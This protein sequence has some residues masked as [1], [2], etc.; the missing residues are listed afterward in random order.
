MQKSGDLELLEDI[1]GTLE[2]TNDPLATVFRTMADDAMDS[3]ADGKS[4][5][6][7]TH[8]S[9]T[10]SKPYRGVLHS[11]IPLW[12]R[13]NY[14]KWHDGSINLTVGINA[15]TENAFYNTPYIG[16][17]AAA[18]QFAADVR[19][20]FDLSKYDADMVRS[21]YNID[22][23]VRH[24]FS[25][26]YDRS[27]L[28]FYTTNNRLDNLSQKLSEAF[29]QEL[30]QA[31]ARTPAAKAMEGYKT[32]DDGSAEPPTP[33]RFSVRRRPQYA[34]LTGAEL[35][36][37]YDEESYN[38]NGWAYV[39]RVLTDQ[40]SDAFNVRIAEIRGGSKAFKRSANGGYIIEFNVRDKSAMV[41]TDGDWD[42]PSI[43]TVVIFE[44]AD[45]FEI[46]K[47]VK[48]VIYRYES[49]GYSDAPQFARDNF[50]EELFRVYRR[51]DFPSF[52]EQKSA[53]ERGAGAAV[54]RNNE[55]LQYR[56]ESDGRDS[57]S[58]PERDRGITDEGETTKKPRF[59]TP[60]SPKA[61]REAAPHASNYSPNLTRT[62][63]TITDGSRSG[64]VTE[65]DAIE[66]I[67]TLPEEQREAAQRAYNS[68]VRVANALEQHRMAA[69]QNKL[70]NFRNN[71]NVQGGTSVTRR[72]TRTAAK[73]RARGA[74]LAESGAYATRGARKASPAISEWGAEL[75]TDA[76]SKTAATFA[77]RVPHEVNRYGYR[78]VIVN[79]QQRT[80]FVT[81]PD[82]HSTDKGFAKKYGAFDGAYYRITISV[83]INDGI[84]TI[85]NVG[86]IKS[87]S[88]PGGIIISASGS[89]ADM[90]SDMD[91]IPQTDDTVNDGG[92]RFSVR[93]SDASLRSAPKTYTAQQARQMVREGQAS[94]RDTYRRRDARSRIDGRRPYTLCDKLK[95][96][97]NA[98]EIIQAARG[99]ICEASRHKRKDDIVEFARGFVT[100]KVG[101]NGYAAD[102]L[103]AIRKNGAAVLYD[104][105]GIYG[106][107][108]SE[109]HVT[110]A[111]QS[112]S[113][114]RHGTSDTKSIPQT[115]DTVKD[116][117]A[118]F[119][120]RN[121]DT[122][123]RSAPKTYTA[124][125]ARQMV[126]E[127]Q[128]IIVDFCQKLDFGR[129][130]RY[131]VIRD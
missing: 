73:A 106:K 33:A 104:L 17:D 50:G 109:A 53:A 62:T 19:R 52:Q 92:A 44:D 83:G 94:V 6:E 54:N 75:D 59:S 91:S 78:K 41:F 82:M 68:A 7:A 21:G 36:A 130:L 14:R 18:R 93:N 116:G 99:W 20:M 45:V 72:D 112:S 11:A 5:T 70:Y 13:T 61:P 84:A 48:E 105:V 4:E 98:D 40:L 8:S 74:A 128:G 66:Y 35:L 95:V 126:R 118:H 71:L 16:I 49:R 114:R 1:A 121:S 102:V 57:S 80:V 58:L 88:I 119:S 39:N 12:D 101:N 9:E 86:K 43:D 64:A 42:S 96:I 79:G 87:D 2:R 28:N 3:G 103:V 10:L 25:R 23:L 38:R 129:G 32:T 37:T 124:Q 47:D 15:A 97:V 55:P 125:Q 60:K 110:M 85:Y 120:A 24:F 81:N 22:Y 108:I 123:L 77:K 76:L 46:V 26:N 29:Q 63:H 113:Q 115:D 69:A 67:R 111:S 117:R 27:L 65:I 90:L 31:A 56:G 107:K 100:Y 34:T 127:G 122:S 51:K 30:D 131:I 89:K